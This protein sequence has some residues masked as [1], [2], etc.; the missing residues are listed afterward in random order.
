MVIGM[1]SN[2]NSGI[3]LEIF[4]IDNDPP[5]I[6]A[7]VD[8]APNANGWNIGPVTV[9]FDCQDGGAGLD[10]CSDPVS[11]TAQGTSTLFGV[12]TD[13]AGNANQIAV[14]V[15]IDSTPPSVSADITPEP[16]PAGWNNLDATV[17]FNASDFISGVASVSPP[18]TVTTEAAGQA[19]N[20]SATD[21]AGNSASTSATVNLD[22]TRPC[23]LSPPR[24]LTRSFLNLS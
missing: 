14:T 9:T 20:G 18:V 19:V 6:T 15:Q 12:A 3:T 11:V 16:N 24:F 13:L 7:T 5:T 1:Q 21:F 2:P 8:P 10:F 22:K 17:T 23:S 4:T